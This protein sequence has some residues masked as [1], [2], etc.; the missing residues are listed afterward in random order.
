MPLEVG[1]LYHLFPSRSGSGHFI[2]EYFGPA[3]DLRNEYVAL[4]T[5]PTESVRK[6]KMLGDEGE[7][8]P[9][10]HPSNLLSLSALGG[11]DS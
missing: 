7:I 1:S 9:V 11:L 10:L 5:P 3:S 6:R 2:A 8:S 4:H